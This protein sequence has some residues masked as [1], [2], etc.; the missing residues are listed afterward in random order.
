MEK[1]GNPGSQG[2]PSLSKDERVPTL[3]LFW[4]HSPFLSGR[5][6][7]FPAEEARLIPSSFY[8]NSRVQTN[9]VNYPPQHNK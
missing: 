8:I 1:A 6:E 3:L 9:Y 4:T 7:P 2:R 5:E